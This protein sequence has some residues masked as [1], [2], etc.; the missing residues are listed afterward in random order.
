MKT[1]ILYDSAYISRLRKENK[2]IGICLWAFCL[3]ALLVCLYLVITVN[4]ANE[5]RNRISV[6][7]VNGVCGCTSI[8]VYLNTVSVNIREISHGENI[9]A[10][11]RKSIEYDIPL[12]IGDIVF[13]VPKSISVRNVTVKHGDEKVILHVNERMVK[14]LRKAPDRGVLT[15]VNGYII[16]YSDESGD[17]TT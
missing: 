2:I 7:I 11:E 4:T 10:G 17:D 6:L 9:F 15:V 8:I 3:A 16:A 14:R 1:I 5:V 12:E 13:P